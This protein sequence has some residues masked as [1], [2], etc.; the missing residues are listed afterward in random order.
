MEE[1]GER[2]HRVKSHCAD[3]SKTNERKKKVITRTSTF[4]NS[5]I[6]LSFQ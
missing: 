4:R 6:G 5:L 2:T 1:V 3:V